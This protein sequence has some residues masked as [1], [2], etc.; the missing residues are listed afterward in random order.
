[1]E[2]ID[3]SGKKQDFIVLGRDILARVESIKSKVI[4]LTSDRVSYMDLK[5][6]L[7]LDYCINYTYNFY[8]SAKELDNTKTKKTLT[9]LKCFMERLKPL[10]V[11]L[12]YQL[13]K[14]SQGTVESELKFKPNPKAMDT[15]LHISEKEGVYQAPK[16]QAAIYEEKAGKEARDD[17][18]LKEKLSRSVLIQS[19]REELGDE[20]L[21]IKS[22]RS[23]KIREIE[24]AQQDWEEENFKRVQITKK[25]KILRRKLQK[26]DEAE[27]E[28][29]IDGFMRLLEPKKRTLQKS[30]DYIAKK[31]PKLTESDE[32]IL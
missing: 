21:E 7:L 13:D 3:A 8:Q 5:N 17:K 24:D 10:D 27:E 6:N 19:L 23:K 30:I 18:R 25:E 12:Q 11:K 22:G 4:N 28:E 31:K 15:Q 32:E 1:M 16:L 14:I 20:P 26:R 2:E 29:N 9:K